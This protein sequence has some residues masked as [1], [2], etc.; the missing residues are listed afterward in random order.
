VR[1]DYSDT[2]LLLLHHPPPGPAHRSSRARDAASGP[3]AHGSC[4]RR[5]PASAGARAHRSPRPP[6][7]FIPRSKNWQNKV[8]SAQSGLAKGIERKQREI[9]RVLREQKGIELKLLAQHSLIP[10][11]RAA[12]FVLL[13]RGPDRFRSTHLSRRDPFPPLSMGRH[14]RGP[15]NQ[16][17]INEPWVVNFEC[18]IRLMF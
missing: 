15:V 3:R 6:G 12:S 4:A 9:R 11:L 13:A 7:S 16:P 1:P 10:F 2:A 17:Q 14:S 5:R 8:K 18:T